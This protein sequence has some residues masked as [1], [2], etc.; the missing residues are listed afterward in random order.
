LRTALIVFSGEYDVSCR[1]QWR[2]ELERLSCEPNVIIDFTNVSYLDATCMT[3]LLRLH[4]RR[5]ASGF[6]RETVV[7]QRPLVRRLFELL[8]M[9]DVLR[10]VETIEE[11]VDK[12]ELAPIVR[13]AFEGALDAVRSAHR[14][15]LQHIQYVPAVGALN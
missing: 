4:E 9:Q 8:Q 14:P 3:E 6:G 13:H 7:L 11:A 10:V 2:E 5:H 1:K 12:K 15:A